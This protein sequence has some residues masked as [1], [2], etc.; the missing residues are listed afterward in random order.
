MT[1]KTLDSSYH[2]LAE[3]AANREIQDESSRFANVVVGVDGSPAGRDAIA[4]GAM[5]RNPQRLQSLDGVDGSVAIGVPSEAL[6]AFGAEVDL[7]VVG[8]RSY[9]P[10]R[11][12]M[13]GSTSLHL[14]REARCP[15]LVL[16]RPIS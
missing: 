13:L 6:A 5:L 1:H 3:L 12:M 2:S 14:A 10:L 7:L 11:R 9:G 15:L 16:P 4:L 8:S